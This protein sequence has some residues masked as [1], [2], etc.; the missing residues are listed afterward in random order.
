MDMNRVLI[1]MKCVSYIYTGFTQRARAVRVRSCSPQ[2]SVGVSDTHGL[3]VR[4][5]RVKAR[6]TR[7]CRRD[8]WTLIVRSWCLNSTSNLTVPNCLYLQP[9]AFG[10]GN[11]GIIIFNRGYNYRRGILKFERMFTT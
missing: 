1:I 5:E 4:R 9:C 2:V 6:V 11:I 10:R 8:L 3:E 7:V